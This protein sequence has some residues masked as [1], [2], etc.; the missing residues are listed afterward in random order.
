M[1]GTIL[2][3]FM[4]GVLSA[5]LALNELLLVRVPARMRFGVVVAGRG[6]LGLS[7]TV[8]ALSNVFGQ[9]GVL[10]ALVVPASAAADRSD[11]SPG[12]ASRRAR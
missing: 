6:R 12:G 11:R 10:I 8:A 9:L 7:A 1:L 3:C 4:M 5:Q 2:G